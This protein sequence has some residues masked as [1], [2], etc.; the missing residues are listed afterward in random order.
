MEA[1]A[2]AVMAGGQLFGFLGVLLA[3]PVAAVAMVLLRYGH[4]RYTQSGL[5]GADAQPP[6]LPAEVE[7]GVIEHT[8]AEES[9]FSDSELRPDV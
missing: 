5:Y 2:I 9:P 7:P 1:V 4:G 3:L 8:D 6:P